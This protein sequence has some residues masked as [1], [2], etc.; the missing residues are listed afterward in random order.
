MPDLSPI[1]D[2]Y[3]SSQQHQI[4]NPLREARDRICNL[5]VPSRI[6]FRCAVT[7]TPIPVFISATQLMGALKQERTYSIKKETYFGIMLGQS[8]VPW[9]KRNKQTN[10]QKNSGGSGNARTSPYKVWG[11]W[12]FNFK[13]SSLS[14]S[15]KVSSVQSRLLTHSKRSSE[16]EHVSGLR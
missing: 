1:C 8:K 14:F 15:Q 6:C 10:K 16:K 2:L 12:S 7:G 3:H 5:M 4:L 9:V 13:F 11:I